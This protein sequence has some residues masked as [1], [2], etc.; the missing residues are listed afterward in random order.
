MCESCILF[1][2]FGQVGRDTNNL[3]QSRKPKQVTTGARPR[4]EAAI[5]DDRNYLHSPFELDLVPFLLSLKLSLILIIVLILR[6]ICKMFLFFFFLFLSRSNRLLNNGLFFSFLFVPPPPPPPKSTAQH[7]SFKKRC[8]ALVEC[9]G[10]NGWSYVQLAAVWPP[11][12][13]TMMYLYNFYFLFF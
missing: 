3:D 8:V 2:L 1:S 7:F 9:S 11:Y 12:L 10:D 4:T 6:C 13:H 5:A